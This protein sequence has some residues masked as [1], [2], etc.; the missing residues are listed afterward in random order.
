MSTTLATRRL[1]REVFTGNSSAICVAVH[2]SL[3]RKSLRSAQ[4]TGVRPWGAARLAVPLAS[5]F[6]RPATQEPRSSH[7]PPVK[8]ACCLDD[9]CSKPN[10]C[11]QRKLLQRIT[12][13]GASEGSLRIRGELLCGYSEEHPGRALSGP[14][15][16]CSG[17]TRVS[18]TGRSTDRGP[19]LTDAGV[20][21]PDEEDQRMRLEEA[22]S[23]A[24]SGDSAL[25]SSPGIAGALY[26]L[27]RGRIIRPQ[28]GRSG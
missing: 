13:V 17:K 3:R 24:E 28:P 10:V 23:S 14:Q 19:V 16:G 9:S 18:L 15:L 21:R 12:L 4:S 22:V 2:S 26:R 1:T 7:S 25:L 27:R 20:T 5:A 8:T 6:T 11:S